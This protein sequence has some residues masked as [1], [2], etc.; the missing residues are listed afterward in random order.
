MEKPVAISVIIACYNHGEYI[1][2]MLESVF[3]Q[4]F[5]EFEV[6]IVNDGSTDDTRKLLDRI[7]HPRL[8]V[9]HTGNHGPSHAR[10]LAITHAAAE[11]IMN[12]DA[13]D[14]IA[15]TL[16]EKA[17]QAFADNPNA[18][19]VYS[20][21]EFFDGKS[22]IFEL[23]YSPRNMLYENRIISQA[24]FRKE[25]WQIT[26]GYCEQLRFGLEDW[27]F[28][29]S[30]LELDRKVV[31]IPEALVFYRAYRDCRK[32]RSG[33][34]LESRTRQMETWLT[35]FRRHQQLFASYPEDWGNFVA[36][37]QKIENETFLVRS[38]KD[39]YY[40]IL[41]RIRSHE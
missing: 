1:E 11:I 35:I 29:L 9:I 7:R 10:N 5:T 37:A 38:L 20:D 25:D 8:T 33:R 27:D 2:E 34:L 14:K 16:L 30:I 39:L 36:R 6:I 40:Y 19:I 3:A 17:Y 22:G 31:K 12:L 41:R 32:C 24:F 4:T 23:D 15:T 13:D 28:W 26:G 18:G 21:A